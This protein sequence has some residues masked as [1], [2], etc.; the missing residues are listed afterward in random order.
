MPHPK[1]KFYKSRSPGAARA[2]RGLTLSAIKKLIAGS[3]SL[4]LQFQ[5]EGLLGKSA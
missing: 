2:L 4:R 1:K 3:R 5:A